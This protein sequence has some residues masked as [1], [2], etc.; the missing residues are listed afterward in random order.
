M[1]F[2]IQAEGNGSWS[3]LLLH[4]W[5]QPPVIMDSLAQ[6]FLIL[7]R[8]QEG[9]FP[10][11]HFTEP[12]A[13]LTKLLHPKGAETQWGAAGRFLASCS[14]PCRSSHLQELQLPNC[15]FTRQPLRVE[16]CLG[17][18]IVYSARNY[19]IIFVCVLCVV[20]VCV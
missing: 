3:L 2:P 6:Y 10:L 17:E 8:R 7:A 19:I 1:S 11:R 18:V 12:H 9:T 20:F 4:G 14:F 13:W 5:E 15:V 16:F